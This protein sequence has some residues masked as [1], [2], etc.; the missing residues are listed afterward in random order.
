VTTYSTEQVATGTISVTVSGTGNLEVDGTTDVYPVTPG[1]VADVK[2]DEGDTVKKGA[3]L[4]TLDAE[5]AEANTAKALASY[6]QAQESV[7]RAEATLVQAEN[8]LADLEDRYADQQSGTTAASTASAGSSTAG[9]TT[10]STNDEVTDSDIENAEMAVESA[11]AGLTSA[12]ASAASALISY[13]QAQEAE[14]DLAVTAPVAGIVWELNVVEGDSVSASDG[15]S[16]SSS[17]AGSASSGGDASASTSSSS[18]SASS[19]PVV[20]APKQPLA[21]HLTVNEVDLPTLEVGQRAEITFDALPDLTA[22]GK[23]YDIAA[24]GSSSSGVVTFDVWLNLDVADDALRPGMSSAA[25]IVTEI[26]KNTLVV[27]NSAVKAAT[28]GSSYVLLM[29]PGASEPVQTPIEV[30]LSNAT[31]TQV[32]SGLSAGDSVVTQS[33]DSSDS[34]EEQQG[35]G[36]MMPLGGGPRG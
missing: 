22:T 20:L 25:T 2:V 26:A 21:V 14:D 11:E 28:D 19:A 7:A 35:G 8:S 4:F 18:S 16:S 27:S 9:A 5:D 33:V 23:V 6:R 24:E 17:S 31:Q 10:Q 30:G 29:R 13:Q 15:G 36:F 34:S 12:R 3:V 1:T 32:I